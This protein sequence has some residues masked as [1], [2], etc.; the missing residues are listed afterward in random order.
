MRKHILKIAVAAALSLV[1]VAL[2]AFSNGPPVRR[3][4]AAV[5]GGLTCTA[6][7]ATF[8]PAN[9]DGRGRVV[10]EANSYATGI[11]QL[12]RVYVEHPEAMRWGFQLTAR[13]ASDETRQAGTFTQT[14]DVRVRCDPA[15]DSPCNGQVEFV[16]QFVAATRV[17]TRGRAEWLVEWTPPSTNVGDVI[18]YVAGNAANGN[19]A[20]SGDRIYTASAR[21][22]ALQCTLNARPTLRTAV[23][24]ASFERTLS[25]N[26]MASVFGLGFTVPGLTREANAADFVDRRFPTQ[27]GCVAVEVAGQLSP[28]AYVQTDQINFQ[29][30]TVTTLGQVPVRVVLNP[31]RPNELRSDVAMVTLTDY[32]PGWFTF[33]GTSIAALHANSD[34][35]VALPAVHPRGRAAAP[36]DVISLYATGLGGTEPFF[37]AGEFSSG[38]PRLTDSITVT[39]GGT[40]LAASDILYAGL[41]PGSI[42]GLYQINL[43]IPA[44]AAN[45][46]LPV[47]L[48]IGGLGTQA[49]ATIP[50]RR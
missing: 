2:E 21:I 22:S 5:D 31:G 36:G 8:A 20:N 1:P 7:H 10:V 27:L 29:V 16:S 9:S 3:T 15:G 39:I 45:G 28:V 25:L 37:Q 13:L 12:V 26:S 4:G 33:N 17:G 35:P 43:R 23:N 11:K 50:V 46:D 44:N 32:A 14:S 30:P 24:G 19:S 18:F 40:T 41:S 47:V 6:C 38:A 42:S 48:R 49:T 34:V